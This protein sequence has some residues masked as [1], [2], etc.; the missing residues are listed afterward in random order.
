MKNLLPY[1]GLV[2]VRINAS[3]KYLPVKCS[4]HFLRGPCLMCKGVRV[5]QRD[6]HRAD[7]LWKS[8]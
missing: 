1:C 5:N 2:D 7:E 4:V 8:W 3:E 6:G